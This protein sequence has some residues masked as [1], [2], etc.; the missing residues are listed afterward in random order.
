MIKGLKIVMIGGGLSY[1]LEFVEGL[2]KWYE[3][4]FVCELWFV[5]IFE[6]EEKLNI[7]GIFVKWMV[8]KVGVLIDIYF[9]LDRREVLKDVDFVMI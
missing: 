4:L 8:E 2:I 5:D 7:V 9:I 6:G 3:E 1:I